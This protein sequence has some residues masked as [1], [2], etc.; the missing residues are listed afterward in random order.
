MKKN[1]IAFS[2]LSL[3]AAVFAGPAIVPGMLTANAEEPKLYSG[4]VKCDGVVDGEYKPQTDPS[5]PGSTSTTPVFVPTN[6]NQ[7]LCNFTALIEQI[8]FLINWLFYIA[9]PIAIALFAWA[10][11]LYMT[12]EPG[13]IKK[14]RSMFTTV[15]VGFGFMLIAWF[16]IYTILKWVVKPGQGFDTLLN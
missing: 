5:K 15:G 9:V 8:Q 14:A 10:G 12:G 7:K 16:V 4:L 2:L 6:P 3:I 13:N 11:F 1:I